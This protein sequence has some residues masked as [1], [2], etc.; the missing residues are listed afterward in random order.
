MKNEN[1][2]CAALPMFLRQR[3]AELTG[4]RNESRIAAQIGYSGPETVR[5]FADGTA[6]VPLDKLPALAKA[7]ECDAAALFRLGIAQYWP[8]DVNVLEAVFG[9]VVTP[10][11]MDLISVW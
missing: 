10:H 9:R 11:E 6:K 2:T 8:G 4:D 3:L 5:A 1:L 7:L